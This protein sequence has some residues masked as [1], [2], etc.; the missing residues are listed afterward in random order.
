MKLLYFLA[1]FTYARNE[2][3]FN[4][5]YPWDLKSTLSLPGSSLDYYNNQ[6][7]LR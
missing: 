7:L 6:E 3:K 4:A 5:K 1:P 2:T